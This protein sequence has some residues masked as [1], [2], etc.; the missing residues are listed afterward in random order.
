MSSLAVDRNSLASLKGKTVLITGG[1]SGFGLETAK[2]L[3][4]ISSSNKIVLLDRDVLPSPF[5]VPSDRV[6]FQQCDVTSWNAQREAFDQA[7]R[8]FGRI[9]A[10]FVNAGSNICRYSV[11]DPARL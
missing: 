9:D 11:T 7:I 4:S 8:K 1:S 10:V 2:L 6:L 5:S 3:L